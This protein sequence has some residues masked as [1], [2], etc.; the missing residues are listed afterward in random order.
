D[1]SRPNGKKRLD[2]GKRVYADNCA[3]CHSSKQP[4]Y[5]L[6]RNQAQQRQ[7]FRDSVAAPDFLAGNTLSDDRRYPLTH[8]GTNMAP[9]P[10]TT[11]RDGDIWAELSSRDYKALPPLGRIRLTYGFDGKKLVAKKPSDKPAEGDLTLDFTPPGGGRG[12]YRTPVL[13][14]LW[15]TAPYLH[16]NALGDYY[17]VNTRTGQK[18]LFPNDGRDLRDA[19]GTPLTI[20][21]SVEGRM[22][23]FQDAA[24]KLLWPE[25]RRYYIKRTV[26]DSR[27]IDLEPVVK[28]LLS[29]IL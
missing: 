2:N 6:V 11:A 20:D 27:I 16:N 8:L 12:Y 1:E 18:W 3:E 28:H 5:S 22:K 17:V 21:T 15:A 29:G 9:A 19:D 4:M 25:K 26:T 7:F 14:S 23:M 24:E 13:V 10:A